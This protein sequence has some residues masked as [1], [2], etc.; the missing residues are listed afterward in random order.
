MVTDS[1]PDPVLANALARRDAA[2]AEVRRWDEFIRT[3]RLLS[4]GQADRAPKPKALPADVS[5]FLQQRLAAGLIG[6]TEALA[7]EIIL[8]KRRAVPTREMLDELAARGH[9]I[10]G[11]NPAG[12][13]SA[14]L[15]R[16][17]SLD[18]QR[19]FGWRLR[20]TDAEIGGAGQPYGGTVP[21][22]SDP[23]TPSSPVEPGAGGGT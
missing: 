7:R 5:A 21:A 4:A 6:E 12:T 8:E 2:L 15:S 10:G 18:N 22:H 16:A 17:P 11:K 20:H 14:R 1:P 9:V 19:P 23:E 13:L 3:Y